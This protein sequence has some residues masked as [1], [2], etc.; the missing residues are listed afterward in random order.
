MWFECAGGGCTVS[1]PSPLISVFMSC[2]W[3]SP[4]SPK[5]D[6]IGR[7]FVRLSGASPVVVINTAL[8]VTGDG[9]PWVDRGDI[10]WLRGEARWIGGD[11]QWGEGRELWPGDRCGLDILPERRQ[12]TFYIYIYNIYNIYII[13]I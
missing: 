9:E 12:W 2:F 11:E 8:F 13:Y 1:T 6:V 10:W 4:N 5:Y 3:C 7:G